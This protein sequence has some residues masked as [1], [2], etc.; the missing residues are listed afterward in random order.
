[1]GVMV[2]RYGYE[3]DQN[4]AA[5]KLLWIRTHVLTLLFTSSIRSNLCGLTTFFLR[6]SIPFNHSTLATLW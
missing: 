1:M 6:E 5:N 4:Y 2:L 3:F